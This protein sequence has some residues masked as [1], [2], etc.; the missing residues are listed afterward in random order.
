MWVIPCMGVRVPLGRT[1]YIR[2]IVMPLP[3]PEK[4]E[5][6]K[7]FMDR[8]MGNDVMNKEFPR[9]GQRAAVCHSQFKKRKKQ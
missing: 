6:E 9:R 4:G 1:V 7:A 2:K 8:C 3:K 5:T